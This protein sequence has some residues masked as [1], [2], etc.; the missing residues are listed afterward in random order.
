MTLRKLLREA[1]LP[2]RALF[3]FP[4]ENM[5]G[6]GPTKM[7]V[8]KKEAVVGGMVTVNWEGEIVQ[9]K[10]I[11][12][13]DS[14]N[15]LHE[16]DILW[17]EENLQTSNAFGAESII[18][19]HGSR[20]LPNKPPE[21]RSRTVKNTTKEKKANKTKDAPSKPSSASTEEVVELSDK[22]QIQPHN[23]TL[24]R[25]FYKNNV[26]GRKN[27]Q[28]TA[29]QE[30]TKNRATNEQKRDHG[31]PATQLFLQEQSKGEEEWASNRRA[32]VAKKLILPLKEIYSADD[33]SMIREQLEAK[34][35]ECDRLRNR[36]H[37]Q[38]GHCKLMDKFE[39]YLLSFKENMVHRLQH[40][41]H[42]P[43]KL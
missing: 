8:H 25:S 36:I 10:L 4:E 16:K 33:L 39:D 17:T 3:F 9:A 12:L 23:L 21:K 35:R 14:H 7:I 2:S 30:R 26:R 42:S 29:E 38:E 1:D 20:R 43:S 37:D 24:T 11:A 18:E 13:S 19:S 6:I 31:D 40:R 41:R 34:T 5:T 27:G 22:E 32:G 28:P 15:E